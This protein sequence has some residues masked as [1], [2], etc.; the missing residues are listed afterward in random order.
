MSQYVFALE[1]MNPLQVDN[2]DSSN[3]TYFCPDCRGKMIIK[4]RDAT[5]CAEKT[6]KWKTPIN[7]PTIPTTMFSEFPLIV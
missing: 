2:A 5:C 3:G 7:E 6:P 1:Y 4:N